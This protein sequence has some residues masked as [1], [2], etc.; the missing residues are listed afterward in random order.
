M[1]SFAFALAISFLTFTVAGG[2]T[3]MVHTIGLNAPNKII[4]APAHSMIVSE[5][6]TT[7]PNTGRLSI[8]DRFSGARHTLISGLPSA[9]SF[10]GGPAGDPDG[11]SG[12]ALQGNRLW[13]TIGVGDSV[14]PGGGPGLET[15]NPT[16]SSPLFDSVLELTL[17]GGFATLD[18]GF[19]LTAA[20][21]LLLNSG[22]T[23]TLRNA[24]D[25]SITIRLVA[26]LPNWRPAPRPDAP[27][28]VKASHLYGV[29]VW[30]K[31]LFLNDAGH[32]DIK[33]VSRITGDWSV[34]VAFPPR[35]NPTPIGGPFIE[36]VPSN[37]HRFG[38][39][40]LVPMLTGFP[41]VQN[42]AEVRRVSLKDASD[43]QFIGGLTSAMD[44]LKV[45]NDGDKGAAESTDAAGSIF[46]NGKR[47]AAQQLLTPGD[48]SSF[49]TLEFSTNMLMGAP[50]RLR[51]YATP[52]AA[53][54]NVLSN[55]IT[56][57]SM[58]RDGEN[59]N[60][61]ITNIG[62]GTITKVTFP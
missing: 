4:N 23:V 39:Q 24:E 57:T 48:G 44:I 51:F 52:D 22:A 50:G 41:F 60:L 59:G 30:N 6:G 20:Q 7:M 37:I 28:N 2:Q 40:L 1:K 56:P 21:Q 11:P 45:E 62:P 38:N 18:S 43:E 9:V 16:P 26:D 61:F 47:D 53:P 35:V 5:A 19:V 14:V 58:A 15:P 32:N 31:S 17:P 55:L 29:E 27:N 46:V 10:L 12:I 34:Y 49:Y 3:A 42:F 36:A 33:Q 8:V 13:M 54:V 25:R